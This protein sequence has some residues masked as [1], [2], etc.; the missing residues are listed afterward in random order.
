MG[1]NYIGHNYIASVPAVFRHVY[2][3]ACR[4]AY[5]PAL[6]AWHALLESSRRGGY[7]ECR[8]VDIRAVDMPSAM[9]T[10]CR[11][12]A[13]TAATSRHA[14]VSTGASVPAV[15]RHVYRRVCRHVYRRVHRHACTCVSIF[16]R[17]CAHSYVQKSVNDVSLDMRIG[18]HAGGAVP[19]RV[20]IHSSQTHQNY[21]CRGARNYFCHGAQNYFAG[22]QNYFF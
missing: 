16:V 13:G 19:C 11:Y 8:H 21:C 10:W 12:R 18:I 7:F 14:A 1:H 5:R 22:C 17:T 15:F 3:H 2:R 4:H 9:P 20:G 6:G